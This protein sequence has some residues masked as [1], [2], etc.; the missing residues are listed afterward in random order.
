[1]AGAVR[2]RCG[3]DVQHPQVRP[4]R[5]V[6]GVRSPLRVGDG[7]PAARAA[8]AVELFKNGTRQCNCPLVRGT[9]EIKIN[10]PRVPRR[11]GTI[12]V[13]RATVGSGGARR[14][15]SGSAAAAPG[16]IVCA[17]FG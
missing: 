12:A 2:P 3:A 16:R 11:L 13:A 17:G 5:R 6:P 4:A 14:C 7:G 15:G 8:K 10:A 9:K 1:M